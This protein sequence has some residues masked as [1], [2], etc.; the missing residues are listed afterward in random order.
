MHYFYLF[1][2]LLLVIMLHYRMLFGGDCYSD[3]RIDPATETETGTSAASAN[4]TAG[5]GAS[6][7]ASALPMNALWLVRKAEYCYEQL[8]NSVESYRLSRLAYSLDPFNEAGL[9][10]YIASMLD[11]NIKTELFYLAHE[12]VHS[13]PKS[14]VTWYAIGCYYYLCNK[15]EVAQKY[16]QK[17]LRINKRF[18][19]AYILLGHVLSLQQENEHALAAYRTVSRL[20]PSDH[21]PLIYMAKELVKTSNFAMALHVLLSALEISRNDS[22]VL[23]ELGA[24]YLQLGR[25]EDALEHLGAGAKLIS[26]SRGLLPGDVA[27]DGTDGNADADANAGAVGVEAELYGIEVGGTYASFS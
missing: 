25:Y 10:L 4:V 12:L 5:V 17:S 8:H 19:K 26:I 2:V 1:F 7:A 21:R 18:A 16:L 15:C 27:A 24:I 20:L 23:N 9:L 6:N 3:Y 14:A 22:T 13:T 11:L